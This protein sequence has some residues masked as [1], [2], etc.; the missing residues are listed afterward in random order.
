MKTCPRCKAQN[1]LNSLFCANCQHKFPVSVFK[2]LPIWAWVG[3]GVGTLC[4]G[5]LLVVATLKDQQTEREKAQIA[6]NATPTP[7]PAPAPQIPVDS[8][9]SN[10]NKSRNDN[11]EGLSDLDKK[12]IGAAGGYLKSLFE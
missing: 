2:S 9:I 11:A 12:Y 10:S 3:I 8:T 5:A 4:F 1:E 7:T 6:A